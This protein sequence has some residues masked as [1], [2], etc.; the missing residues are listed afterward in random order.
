MWVIDNGFVKQSKQYFFRTNKRNNHWTTAKV[1]YYERS[2]ASR[3]NIVNW[4]VLLKTM[5]IQLILTVL[6]THDTVISNSFGNYNKNYGTEFWFPKKQKN[7]FLKYKFQKT[8]KRTQRFCFLD[9]FSGCSSN[10]S[11][12]YSLFIAIDAFRWA[13]VIIVDRRGGGGA[14]WGWGAAGGGVLVG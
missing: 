14:I 7:T 6:L 5:K 9:K 4:L 2:E 8:Q 10:P 13:G 1:H 3:K 12:G 11:P